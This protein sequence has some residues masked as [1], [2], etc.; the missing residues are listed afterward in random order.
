MGLAENSRQN[1]DVKEVKYQAIEN[2]E[3]IGATEQVGLTVTASVMI[4]RIL[5]RDKVGCHREGV[6]R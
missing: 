5:D 3:V 6:E 2:M 1:L 4:A